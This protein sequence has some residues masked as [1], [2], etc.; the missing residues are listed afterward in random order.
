ME[1]AVK[2]RFQRYVR[3]HTRENICLA[4]ATMIIEVKKYIIATSKD[5]PVAWTRRAVADGAC[6]RVAW[7]RR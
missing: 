7:R 4:E 6:R 3:N 5:V 2:R 1:M